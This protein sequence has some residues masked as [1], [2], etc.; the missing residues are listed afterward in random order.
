MEPREDLIAYWF[1]IWNGGSDKKKMHTKTSLC[2]FPTLDLLS[3][4]L[5]TMEALCPHIIWKPKCL[6][7]VLRAVRQG[8]PRVF[9]NRCSKCPVYFFSSFNC[10][11]CSDFTKRRPTL[12]QEGEGYDT[13][14]LLSQSD[15]IDTYKRLKTLTPFADPIPDVNS[16]PIHHTIQEPG[17]VNVR[18]IY[19]E[20]QYTEYF[21]DF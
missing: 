20:S 8:Y 10:P 15:P 14:D 1:K 17:K 18:R 11:A 7:C 19:T 9:F 6:R 3:S 21:I 16:V 12:V 2:P 5:K 4:F 13:V